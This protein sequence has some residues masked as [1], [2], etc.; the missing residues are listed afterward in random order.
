MTQAL[1]SAL[2]VHPVQLSPGGRHRCGP[3]TAA[4]LLAVGWRRAD[5]IFCSADVIYL[6][7]DQMYSIE[8]VA[9]TDHAGSEMGDGIR[10]G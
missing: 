4:R 6:T 2:C 7:C 1:L 5:P 10:N 3:A 8:S 9:S